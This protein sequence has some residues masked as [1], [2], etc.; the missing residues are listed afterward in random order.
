[1]EETVII[2]HHTAMVLLVS[3]RTNEAN[4]TTTSPLANARANRR[5]PSHHGTAD[6]RQ[7]EKGSPEQAGTPP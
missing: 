4:D 5:Q 2:T 6:T 7:S 1:V 3:H